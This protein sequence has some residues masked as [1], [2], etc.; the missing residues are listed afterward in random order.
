MAH[1]T[2]GDSLAAEVTVVARDR[3]PDRVAVRVLGR[4]NRDIAVVGLS[5]TPLLVLVYESSSY[6]IAVDAV[7]PWDTI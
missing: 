7:I 5:V 1:I 3:L 6:S 2:L 4:L